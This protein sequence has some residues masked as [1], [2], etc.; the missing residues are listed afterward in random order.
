MIKNL[1]FASMLFA[2]AAS[3][4]AQDAPPN[5]L[6]IVADDMGYSDIGPFG[7]EI[8]TPC[9]PAQVTS[10]APS[11]AWERGMRCNQQL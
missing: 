9:Q 8:A 1:W 5:V 10:I 2:L 6:L 11:K 4:V 7:G 3:S